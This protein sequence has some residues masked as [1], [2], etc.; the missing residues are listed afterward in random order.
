MQLLTFNETC[1]WKA[2]NSNKKIEF[3]QGYL[4]FNSKE[5]RF[6]WKN[7]YF[8]CGDYHYVEN[9]FKSDGNEHLLKPLRDNPFHFSVAPKQYR[10]YQDLNNKRLLVLSESPAIG[11]NV[12]ITAALKSLYQKVKAKYP[13]VTVNLVCHSNVE[14]VYN[15]LPFYDHLSVSPCDIS[16]FLNNDFYVRTG[17]VLNSPEF[18][19]KTHFD[20]FSERLL[21]KPETT[22]TYVMANPAYEF[23][24][25]EAIAKLKEK[26][27][28][29]VVLVNWKASSL[30]RSITLEKLVPV[31]KKFQDRFHFVVIGPASAAKAI[32]I[33]QLKTQ[34]GFIHN[35]SAHNLSLDHYI[36][37]FTAL[38]GVI[39]VNTAAL[40]LANNFHKPCVGLFGCLP[41]EIPCS[42]F[43]RLIPV[44][45]TYKGETCEAPC[46]AIDT[47]GICSEGEKKD[48]KHIAPCMQAIP[49]EALEQALEKLREACG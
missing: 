40:H 41:W 44:M 16:H 10:G 37:A 18:Y 45:A 6:H 23:V 8:E 12:I 35:L 47:R 21:T 4:S 22:D 27:N 34:T 29:P 14:A 26:E 9:S 13:S 3:Q 32:A 43:Q 36:A 31:L 39:S 15:F 17:G 11:D 33:E 38:D 20:F 28:K 25:K 42:H 2:P 19:F 30:I 7:L 5:G 49:E 46:Y 48:M 1:W 24:W